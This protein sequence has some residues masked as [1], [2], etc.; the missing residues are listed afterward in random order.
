MVALR[1]SVLG[2]VSLAIIVA[3]LSW[4]VREQ[5]VSPF[6]GVGRF[7]KAV[8]DPFIKPVER[9]MVR[10]G[11]NPVH[12]G[13]WLVFVTTVVGLVVLALARWLGGRASEGRA[14]GSGGGRRGF[15]AR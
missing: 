13:W 8:S 4:L 2:V 6:S 11:G 1:Y 5:H 3:T 12:A 7:C 14:A 15:A 9:R 10:S